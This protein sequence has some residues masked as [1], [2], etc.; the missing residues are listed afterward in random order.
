M[1]RNHNAFRDL[2]LEMRRS[3]STESRLG[4]LSPLSPSVPGCSRTPGVHEMAG[5][6][7][8]NEWVNR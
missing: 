4:L 7:P 5:K 8:L 2:G 6:C 3:K 1:D